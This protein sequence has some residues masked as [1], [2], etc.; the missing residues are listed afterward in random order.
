MPKL[1]WDYSKLA[2]YYDKRAPYAEDAVDVLLEAVD[3]EPATPV[4][5]IGAGTGKL[6]VAL[7][8]RGLTVSAVEPNDEMRK[9][10]I[11]NTEG[12]PVSWSSGTGEETGLP[13]SSFRLATFGSSFNVLDRSRALAEVKRILVPQGWFACMWNHRNLNDSIQSDVEQ[14][15]K[16]HVSDYAYGTRREDQTEVLEESA[17]FREINKV[18]AG[19]TVVVE[20]DDYIEAWRSHGTLARQAGQRFAEVIDAIRLRLEGMVTLEVSY[21]TRVWYAQLHA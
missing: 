11:Q 16:D 8:R 3:A 9:Y 4:A 15:I 19:F 2:G 7:A 18:E 1:D 10:G 20:L 21:T 14:I 13:D 5:D 17:L 12:M 6:T